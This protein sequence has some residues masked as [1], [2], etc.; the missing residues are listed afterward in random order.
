MNKAVFDTIV[1]IAKREVKS[2]ATEEEVAYLNNSIGVSVWREALAAAINDIDDQF[3]LRKDRLDQLNKQFGMGIIGKD[4]FNAS[5]AMIEDW[6]KKA[7]RYKLGL[8][9]RLHEI[10]ALEKEGHVQ[11][12]TWKYQFEEIVKAVKSHQI[13]RTKP[14][15]VDK[16]LWEI[17]DRLIT[18]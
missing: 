4:E 13:R 15:V 16:E 6:R 18:K 14:S 7:A 10:K 11:A 2:M 12:T 5:Y 3:N 17:V 1:E 8:E 9:N